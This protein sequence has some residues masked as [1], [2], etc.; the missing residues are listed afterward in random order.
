VALGEST[1]LAVHH[2]DAAGA[3]SLRKMYSYSIALRIWHQNIT[4]D[5]ITRAMIHSQSS[6]AAV[7]GVVVS[8]A[9]AE[10]FLWGCT[11]Y[12]K[13]KGHSAYWG[14]FGLLWILGLLVLVF[15]PDRNKA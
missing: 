8:L 10:L 4:P 6:A 3:V 15:L 14:A 5:L 2:T 7:L 9:G 12:A 13:G 1:T 11:Q